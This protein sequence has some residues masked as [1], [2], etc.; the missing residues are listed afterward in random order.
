ML[1]AAQIM[2]EGTKVEA[3]FWDKTADVVQR[4]RDRGERYDLAIA[5][6]TLSE[7]THDNSRR[8]A[9]QVLYELLDEGGVLVLI[10]QGNPVGSHIVRSARK[11]ILDNFNDRASELRSIKPV[12]RFPGTKLTTSPKK[13]E[14]VDPVV[15]LLLPAPRDRTYRELRAAVIAPCSH[16]DKCPLAR[17]VFCSFSQKVSHLSACHLISLDSACTVLYC[18]VFVCKLK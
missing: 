12:K 1:E 4:A 8:A 7:L 10:E 11:F 5:S 13:D 16:D 14:S 3:V 6:Y 17:G 18:T 9:V 15:E 2:M